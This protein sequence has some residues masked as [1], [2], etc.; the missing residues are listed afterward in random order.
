[1]R[2]ARAGVGSDFTD[3]AFAHSSGIHWCGRLGGGGSRIRTLG[4][5]AHGELG[6]ICARDA[7]YAARREARNAERGVARSASDFRIPGRLTRV[8]SCREI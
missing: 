7:T 3:P 5:P 8:L 4:P 1:V 2:L 6:A